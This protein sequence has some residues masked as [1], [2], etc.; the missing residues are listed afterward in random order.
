MG[1]HEAPPPPTRRRSGRGSAR[2]ERP[3]LW[4][5]R[6][7]L[8]RATGAP[9]HHRQPTPRGPARPRPPV[10]T[11]QRRRPRRLPRAPA[12]DR[13]RGCE[14]A[15]R[16]ARRTERPRSLSIEHERGP[17]GDGAPQAFA[18]RRPGQRSPRDAFAGA[19][20]DDSL[21]A[22]VGR[23]V[24][25]ETKREGPPRRR[26]RHLRTALVEPCPHPIGVGARVAAFEHNA[27]R[28]GV[29]DSLSSDGQPH[30]EPST[31]LA[32]RPQ[33]PEMTDTIEQQNGV[34]GPRRACSRRRL[35]SAGSK[36]DA[37]SLK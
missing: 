32:K 5:R 2:R 29:H 15:L 28:F 26:R 13:R 19:V 34:D 17:D 24:S 8:A 16:R 23:T 30:E 3:L 12:P 7:R 18:L 36:S 14:I 21:G 20:R 22:N 10:G 6:P 33:A 4:P 31:M 37:P 25:R 1:R 35:I 27:R 11:P 9:A